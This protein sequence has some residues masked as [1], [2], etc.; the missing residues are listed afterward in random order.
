MG[1][2]ALWNWDFT[3]KVVILDSDKVT[4]LVNKWKYDNKQ[5]PYKRN[6][7]LCNLALTR[8]EEI[9]T[10]W[11]HDGFSNKDLGNTY[12]AKFGENLYRTTSGDNEQTVLNAWLTSPGHRKNLDDKQFTQMCIAC[13]DEYCV[14][15]FSTSF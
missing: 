2:I 6:E 15:I 14:Q 8:S 13:Q 3:E 11:S 4:I 12:Q 7:I 10:D 9:K 5:Q 1:L